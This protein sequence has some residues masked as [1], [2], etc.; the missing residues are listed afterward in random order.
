MRLHCAT[1][2]S[3]FPTYLILPSGFPGL[4]QQPPNPKAASPRVRLCGLVAAPRGPWPACEGLVIR[5]PFS[6][7][8]NLPL[9]PS[10]PSSSFKILPTTF[11]QLFR[12]SLP[13]SLCAYSFLGSPRWPLS[14]AFAF[15]DLLTPDPNGFCH[16][17]PS[18]G[19][20]STPPKPTFDS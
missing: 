14:F 11:T 17:V 12:C 4:R 8:R 16:T 18:R 19:K 15:S 5:M 1:P 3:S 6:A 2:T 10:V 13:H 20:I 7:V 9:P